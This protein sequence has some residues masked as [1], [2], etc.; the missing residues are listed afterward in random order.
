MGFVLGASAL[1]PGFAHAQPADLFYERAVMSA[2][3]QRCGLFAPDVGVALAAATAQARGAALR[4][5]VSIDALRATERAARAKAAAADCRSA[6]IAT[7][8]TRV[9]SAFAGFAKLT[10]LTYAGDVA[11]WAADRNIS[12]NLR[13]QLQQETAFGPDRM[14]FGLAGRDGGSVLVAVARFADGAEPYAAHLVLRD[15]ARSAQPYLARFGGGSTAGLPLAQ[16][17]PPPGAQKTYA[18]AGRAPAGPDLL[19][20]GVTAGWAF[21]FSDEASQELAGLDPR[22]S[23]AVEFLFPG[24]VVRRAYVEV[25]DFAA[26]RAFLQLA[27]R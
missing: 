15:P 7:A 17:L 9:K 10:R 25:G 14:A 16:R 21:R 6:D 5:G 26:G 18:A 4:A 23:V 11:G 22:E 20:K 8:A 24:D 2:A 13:W 12:R 1:T 27:A 19:P 3:D